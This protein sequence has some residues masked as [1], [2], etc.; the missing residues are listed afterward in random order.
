MTGDSASS[1][2]AS[3]LIDVDPLTAVMIGVMVKFEGKGGGEEQ[4]SA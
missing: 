4:K 3:D 2:S 1:S